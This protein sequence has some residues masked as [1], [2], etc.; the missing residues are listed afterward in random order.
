M[1]DNWNV[2]VWLRCQL[3]GTLDSALWGTYQLA[4]GTSFL[5]WCQFL[6]EIMHGRA[7]EV[8][9]HHHH[10]CW[11]DVIPTTKKSYCPWTLKGCWNKNVWNCLNRNLFV[12]LLL[13]IN[14]SKRLFLKL[15]SISQFFWQI[16]DLPTKK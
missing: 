13:Y 16:N 10:M 7:P 11:W 8:F 9:L 3:I 5:L 4:Y 1:V 6:L 14:M 12:C 15:L 2:P